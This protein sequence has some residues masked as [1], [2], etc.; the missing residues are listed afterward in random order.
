MHNDL[1]LYSAKVG[2]ARSTA[3]VP[4]PPLGRATATAAPRSRQA[5]AAPCSPP[6]SWPERASPCR[7]PPCPRQV[8]PGNEVK[9]SQ[10][11]N[12]L[13]MQGAIVVA[14]RGD[15][16]HTSGHAYQVRSAVGAGAGA[17]RRGGAECCAP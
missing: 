2:G 12:G 13:S 17:A 9:V 14:G 5:P 3:R 16:L 11:L 1:V 15:N 10:M 6:V 4:V 8:I 7:S